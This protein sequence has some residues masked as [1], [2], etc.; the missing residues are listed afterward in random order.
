M[1]SCN[2]NT[3]KADL[4]WFFDRFLFLPQQETS[5]QMTNLHRR[6]RFHNLHAG[7]RILYLTLKAAALKLTDTGSMVSNV[8]DKDA[9]LPSNSWWVPIVGPSK[10]KIF[11]YCDVQGTLKGQCT[12]V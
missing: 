6:L 11:C 12:A 2:G 1:V 9:L 3:K 4:Y 8:S 7:V 5:A 10:R